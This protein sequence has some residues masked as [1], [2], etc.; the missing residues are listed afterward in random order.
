MIERMTNSQRKYIVQKIQKIQRIQKITH[1]RY[2]S[3]RE[4]VKKQE[5]DTSQSDNFEEILNEEKE[6]LKAASQTEYKGILS[7]KERVRQ[8]KKSLNDGYIAYQKIIEHTAD[9]QEEKYRQ[10]NKE[11]Y[12]NDDRY[13]G[14]A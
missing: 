11:D 10:E 8:F 12:E 6:K 3:N 1:T 4:M 5:K 2:F 14:K 7:E 9:M 13:D